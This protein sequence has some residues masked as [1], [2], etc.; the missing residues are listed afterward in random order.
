[1]P[2][3]THTPVRIAYEIFGEGPEV[4]LVI[5]GWVS[6]LDFD[7]ET[8]E[9]RGFYDRLAHGR[10]VI[11]YDK[12][13]VGL[14]DR[15]TGP[16]TY[17]LAEQV[18]DVVT[19]LDTAG[20]ERVAIF[21]WSMGGPI[22]LT[23]A[24]EQPER[25]T[26]LVLYGTYAKALAESSYPQGIDGPTMQSLMSLA[27]AQWG[28]G[29]GAI[30]SFFIPESDE[31]RIRWFTRYQRVAMSPQTAADFVGGVITHDVREILSSV[32]TPT[33]VLHR[34]ED[35]LVPVALGRYLAERI[36]GACFQELSGQHHTP[37]F[38]DS[39][40][41]TKATD[42]FL[43]SRNAGMAR[44][45]AL[46]SRE[47]AVLRLLAEGLHNREIAERLSISPAT[48]SRHLANIY[49][50]LDVTTRAAAAAYAYRHNLA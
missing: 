22:G 45:A 23:L 49:V 30:A 28:I 33:L 21:A 16:D 10:R 1:M 19:V 48:V 35:T 12:R 32:Q 25:V 40:A 15:P 2:R 20:L 31:E 17:S 6:H 8:P 13:G 42:A 14:S 29:S 24:A 43:R 38:G 4:L 5:P 44:P 50:K 26:S 34:R 3:L 18:R 27:R 11:R 7:W 47:I 36:P 37:Y 39:E 9:I 46:T 41:I